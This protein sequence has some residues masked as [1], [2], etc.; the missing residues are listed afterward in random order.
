MALDVT[1]DPVAHARLLRRAHERSL[2][3]GDGTPDIRELDFDRAVGG[4][5]TRGEAPERIA[6][7]LIAIAARI[8]ARGSTIQ[9]SSSRAS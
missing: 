7:A 8:W 3:G 6:I 5:D 4:D 2:A 9:P 1:T